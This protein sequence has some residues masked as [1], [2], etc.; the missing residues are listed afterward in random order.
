MPEELFS[1]LDWRDWAVVGSIQVLSQRLNYKNAIDVAAFC[2]A[3]GVQ[4]V[5]I[6]AQ[7]VAERM[8][9]NKQKREEQV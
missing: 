5:A 8:I 7:V 3:E 2:H 4:G 9:A 1:E 6:V